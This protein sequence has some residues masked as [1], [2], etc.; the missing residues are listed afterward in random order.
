MRLIDYPTIIRRA[1]AAF[2][3]SQ[4]VQSIEDISARVSTNH[5]FRLTLDSGD[6]VIAKL[7]YFGKFDH[8]RDDHRIIHTLANN[9]LYP[10]ENVLA[11]SLMKNGQ[12]FT[13]RHQEGLVDAWVVFYN[14]IRAKN[15]LPRR[16]D[17]WH[18]RRLGGEIA[19]FHLACN[20]ASGVL[21]KYAK[22][23]RSDIQGLLDLLDT[24]AGQYEHRQNENAIRQQCNLFL[25]N[26][27]KLVAK[28]VETMPVF[29]DWNIG[30]FSVTEGLHLYSRWDY[31]W[32]RISYRVMDF[33]FFSRV[34][35]DVGDRT[36]FSYVIGPLMEE[37]FGWFLD[38][39]HKVYPLTEREIRFLPEAYRFF[40]L[41]YV[42]KY[43]RYFFHRTYA[44][45]LQREAFETYFP[46]I[47]TFDADKI[48]RRLDI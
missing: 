44:S 2:D 36:V 6:R 48:L 5:V 39:Y 26:R 17:E 12:V 43:G 13:Y 38:E 45:K 33:Y 31:D 19:R 37:R 41:N 24:D 14:P 9:L 42:I 16:L 25:E 8:F 7:S 32:F 22:T 11:K 28:V 23:L 18:I 40:I 34:C 4:T 46:S 10:F 1:W 20:R 27:Q 29:V 15:R 47:E 35:S 3:P 30:N 21:P